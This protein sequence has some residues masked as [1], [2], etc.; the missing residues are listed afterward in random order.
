MKVVV[1]GGT[2]GMGRFTVRDLVESPGVKKILCA[3]CRGDEAKKFAASFQDPRIKGDFVDAY[4][5]DK[6]AKLMKGYDI[7]INAAQYGT[8]INVMKACL[9][10]GLHYVDLGGLFHGGNKQIEE[11]GDAF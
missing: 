9:K 8:N 7:V 1:I 11:C 5:V 10:E 6:T 4:E 3:D 2:G